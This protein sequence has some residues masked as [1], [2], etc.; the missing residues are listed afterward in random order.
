[1]MNQSPQEDPIELVRAFR[2]RRILVIGD[3]LLDSYLPRI[4]Q[5]DDQS[6]KNLV[7]LPLRKNR[8]AG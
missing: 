7:F 3:A 4:A 6:G 2:H 1:M 8:T 5:R